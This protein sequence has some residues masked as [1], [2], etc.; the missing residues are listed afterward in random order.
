LSLTEK[1]SKILNMKKELITLLLGISLFPSFL[2]GQMSMHQAGFRFGYS[3]GIFYQVSSAAGNAEIAYNAMLSFR[4][5]GLQFTG[6]RIV[7][8]TSVDGISPDLFFGWGYGGHLGFIYS[9]HVKF[10]GEDYYFYGERF[11]PLLGV[12]GWLT[13]EYRIHEIPVNVSLNLKPFIELTTPSFFRIVP[14]DFAVSI[15]YVF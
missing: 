1:Y 2:A 8:E 6:L 5:D 12:D 7:Y 15:S 4:R 14:W 10:R 13:A 3:S 9:D 11:C